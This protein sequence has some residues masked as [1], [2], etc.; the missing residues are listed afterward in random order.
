MSV[1][2]LSSTCYYCDLL[3]LLTSIHEYISL[4]HASVPDY[5]N[6]GASQSILRLERPSG[7]WKV[8]GCIDQQPVFF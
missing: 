8:T 1:S 7:N 5:I 4:A 6:H 2:L 3:L